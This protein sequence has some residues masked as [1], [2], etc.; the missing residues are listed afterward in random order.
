MQQ[1]LSAGVMVLVNRHEPSRRYARGGHHIRPDGR[2]LLQ[3]VLKVRACHSGL[4][5]RVFRQPKSL[6]F[7]RELIVDRFNR[8]AQCTPPE[9]SKQLH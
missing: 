9:I 6:K 4:R 8:A 3:Q 2:E 7:S 1:V 5:G